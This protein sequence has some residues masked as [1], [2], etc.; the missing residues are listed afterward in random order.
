[1]EDAD[2]QPKTPQINQKPSFDLLPS[3]GDLSPLMNRAV[4]RLVLHAFDESRV[5]TAAEEM[6]AESIPREH[7][8]F[9]ASGS[10]GTAHNDLMAPIKTWSAEV[11]IKRVSFEFRQT[12]VSILGPFPN[13]AHSITKVITHGGMERNRSFAAPS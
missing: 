3:S 12:V 7:R 6:R 4:S 2:V 11:F 13:V 9:I 1:M 5:R 8:R 10:P